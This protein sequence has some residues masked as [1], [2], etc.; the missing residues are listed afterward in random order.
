[1]GLLGS[2]AKKGLSKI[3]GSKIASGIQDKIQ[4]VKSGIKAVKGAIKGDGDITGLS[5]RNSLL[6]DFSSVVRARIYVFKYDSVN[7]NVPERFSL[8][9]NLPV[10]INPD[11]YE[12]SK[13]SDVD[14]NEVAK[15]GNIKS[16]NEDSM[17]FTLRFNIVDEY[18]LLTRDGL[19]P[20]PLNLDEV[21]IISKLYKYKNSQYVVLFKW[22]P[23]AYL[24]NIV[25]VSCS[26]DS[27]SPYGEPLS[28]DVTLEL[29]K[30]KKYML[31]DDDDVVDTLGTANWAMI[32][33]TNVAETVSGVVKSASEYSETLPNI[34]RRI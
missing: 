32:K 31:A 26:Y 20:I 8:I 19:Y 33:G 23:L 5:Y 7:T 18:K 27:F 4:Q 28:A 21:T 15:S 2:I 1:M 17:S 6:Y 22:G 30:F 29:A 25:K 11:K 12:R 14:W 3:G 9:D 16:S 24:S 13:S 34:A 10:Q